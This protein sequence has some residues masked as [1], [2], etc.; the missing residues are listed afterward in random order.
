M[1]WRLR[2]DNTS[3]TLISGQRVRKS[4]MIGR[5][6]SRPITIGAVI[7]RSP[8]GAAYSPDAARSASL[9][10]SRM[11]LLAANLAADRRQRHAQFM[12][13]GGQAAGFHGADQKGHGFEAVHGASKIRENLFQN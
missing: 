12:A 10:C 2:S 8:L 3:R 5:T 9:T 6:C 13:G 7:T 11:R 1:R 4:L